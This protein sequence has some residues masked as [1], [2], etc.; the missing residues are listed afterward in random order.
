[1]RE[2][3]IGL[4]KIPSGIAGFDTISEGGLPKGKTTLISGTPGSG[5]TIFCTQFLVYGIEKLDEPGVFVTFEETPQDIIENMVDFGWDIQKY[6]ESGK[7]AFVDVSPQFS[8]EFEFSGDYDLSGLIIR[9]KTAVEKIGAKRIVLDSIAA[10]FSQFPD[11]SIV[12]KEILRLKS[13]L[14]TLNITALITS[15]RYEEYKFDSHYNIIDFVSDN[16]I[17]LRNL[18]HEEYRRRTIE[19]LKYRGTS[20]KKGQYS[21]TIKDGEGMIIISFERNPKPLQ[22]FSERKTSGITDLDKITKGGLFRGSSILISGQTGTGKTLFLISMIK[23]ILQKG[24][25]CLMFNF[26]ESREQILLKAQNWDLDLEKAEKDGLFRLLCVYP[27][28]Q[29]IEELIVDMRKLIESFKPNRVFIDSISALTRITNEVTYRQ[30]LINLILLFREKN[31]IGFL[32]STS[33]T[34]ASPLMSSDE[35]ISTLSDA[36]ILLRYFEMEGKL[37][38]GISVIKLRGSDHTKYFIEYKIDKEGI[39]LLEPIE[40]GIGAFNTLT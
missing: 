32:T 14:L 3:L 6:V 30:S 9:I 28:S 38:R 20:H 24:E 12:R 23:G 37:S 5:K 25:K 40:K 36:I 16:L 27:E 19:I 35:H 2:N 8:E 15:E 18:A 31:I 26:E 13:S 22:I 39:T 7:W 1:M 34:F 4:K 17:I 33:P 10:L 21:F 29:G 11:H